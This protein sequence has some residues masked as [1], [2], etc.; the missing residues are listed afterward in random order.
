MTT[1]NDFL[2]LCLLLF[3]AVYC[4]LLLFT[5]VTT[6]I[7][8]IYTFVPFLTLTSRKTSDA[9]KLGNSREWNTR[10]PSGHEDRRYVTRTLTIPTIPTQKYRGNINERFLKVTLRF[11]NQR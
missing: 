4:C 9:V 2:L 8:Y 10:K 3:T 11:D 1:V 7:L 5:T 6:I